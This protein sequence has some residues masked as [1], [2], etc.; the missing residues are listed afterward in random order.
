VLP[1]DYKG[2]VQPGGWNILSFVGID[3]NFEELPKLP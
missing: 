3:D 1:N 2:H